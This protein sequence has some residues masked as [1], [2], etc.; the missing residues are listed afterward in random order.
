[1]ARAAAINR[2]IAMLSPMGVNPP[3]IVTTP[4][5]RDEMFEAY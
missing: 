5:G 4:H 1:V 3:V 2:M